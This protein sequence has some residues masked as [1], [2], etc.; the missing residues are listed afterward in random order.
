MAVIKKPETMTLAELK[1][2]IEETEKELDF[3]YE[4]SRK[5]ENE[6]KDK[7]LQTLR[8]QAK[9]MGFDFFDIAKQEIKANHIPKYMNPDNP[10]E[11]FDGKG[12][13]FP[14][15]MKK[16]LEE[17]I[18]KDQLINPQHPDYEKI[19]KADWVNR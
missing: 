9:Q 12:R 8:E 3:L 15:W 5:K 10:Q 17:G 2:K 11:T 1:Q 4:I 14:K 18:P 16:K 6:E 7:V 13:G 19:Q